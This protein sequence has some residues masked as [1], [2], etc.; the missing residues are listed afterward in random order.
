MAKQKQDK[1]VNSVKVGHVSYKV[2]YTKEINSTDAHGNPNKPSGQVSFNRC[3]IQVATGINKEAMLPSVVFHE[4]LH[5]VLFQSGHHEVSEGV[6]LALEYG[7]TA[8]LRD[9]PKL[10]EWLLKDG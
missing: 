8:L 2:E 9:N 10:V 6:V 3:I 1:P 4:A 5:A 7:L